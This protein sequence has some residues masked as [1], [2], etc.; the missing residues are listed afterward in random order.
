MWPFKKKRRDLVDLEERSPQ[1]GIKYKDLMVME[2]LAKAGAALEQSRHVV[3][4]LYA[5][6][7]ELGQRVA[8]EVHGSPFGFRV[9]VGKPSAAHPDSWPVSCEVNAVVSPDFVRATGDLFDAIA[10]Q[11]GVEYDGWEAAATP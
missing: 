9:E 6:T 2:Q 1:L 5:P 4:Y 7:L 3:F 11:H 10:Q 8:K